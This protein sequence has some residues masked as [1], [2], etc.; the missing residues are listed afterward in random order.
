VNDVDVLIRIATDAAD[1]ARGMDD[2][3]KHALDM[4]DDVQKA[5][6]DASRS[7]DGV[8]DAVDDTGSK[9]SQLAG[10]FGDVAGGL[11][12]IGLGGFSD[13]LEAAAPA[14]MLTAGAADIASVAM[15]T[16]SITKIKDTAAT[17]ANKAASIAAATAA[18]AQAVAQWLLNA[19][20]SANPIMLVVLAVVALVAIIVVAYKRSETFRNIVNA[21]GRAGRTAIG[22]IVDKVRD[23]IRWVGDTAPK[24]W[25]R[26]KA[27]ALLAFRIITLPARTYISV[28]LKIV[29]FVRDKIPVAVNLMKIGLVKAFEVMTRPIRKVVDLIKSVVDWIGKIDLGFLE[30]IGGAIGGVL[31]RTSATRTP[32]DT[33]WSPS[34]GRVT[35]PRPATVVNMPIT[36]NGAFDPDASARQI[37]SLVVG[38]LRRIGAVT[39]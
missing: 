26:L 30:D 32:G 9:A 33:P 36:V 11:G 25:D 14:L 35:S 28:L 19:A 22:W 4:A 15:N 6:R 7:L 39:T 20:M 27:A 12:L 1:G 10:A 5:S 3:G 24:A 38:R 23:L 2:V 34:A 29:G 17:V 13:E 16:L 18:K 8:G 31:G 21:V 37:Q